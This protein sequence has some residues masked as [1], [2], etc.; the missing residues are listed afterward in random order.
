MNGD[1]FIFHPSH[2]HLDDVAAVR[3]DAG[4]HRAEVLVHDAVD[5]PCALARHTRGLYFRWK[6]EIRK[7]ATAV[8][9]TDQPMC[10]CSLKCPCSLV[11]IYAQAHARA[12]L[13]VR[14]RGSSTLCLR[15]ARGRAHLPI[16]DRLVQPGGEAREAA[17]VRDH[18]HRDVLFRGGP[19]WVP[20]ELLPHLRH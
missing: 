5:L 11:R 17:D 19:N 15:A 6:Q 1:S 12:R 13:P 9:T 14:T 10:T 4:D 2:S 7:L 16:L 8:L 3:L 18:D 20:D